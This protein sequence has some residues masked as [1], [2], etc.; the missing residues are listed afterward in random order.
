[1]RRSTLTHKQNKNR[2]CSEEI[3]P[4]PNRKSRSPSCLF[5]SDAEQTLLMQTLPFLL[6]SC[7]LYGRCANSASWSIQC[8]IFSTFRQRQP[9]S[10]CP[11]VP[12]V[13]TSPRGSGVMWYAICPKNMPTICFDAS[14]STF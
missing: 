12:F 8:Q 7:V 2:V 4:F 6:S 5:G 10:F 11:V 13:C 1:M 9:Y 3:Q 14:A